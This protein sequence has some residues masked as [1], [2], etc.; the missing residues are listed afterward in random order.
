M[1]I[2]HNHGRPSTSENKENKTHLPIDPFNRLAAIFRP[3]S[4]VAT[5]DKTAPWLPTVQNVRL[6]DG[7]IDGRA[8][9]DLAAVRAGFASARA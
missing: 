2:V 4:T 1:Q 8:L 7:L 9:A 5:P 3:L 6:I